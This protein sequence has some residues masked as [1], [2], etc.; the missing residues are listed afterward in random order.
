MHSRGKK[1]KVEQA[2][3]LCSRDE[4]V[5][6]N[7]VNTAVSDQRG[8]IEGFCG[9][10]VPLSR[11]A[12]VLLPEEGGSDEKGVLLCN[13]A[14]AA[15]SSLSLK[16]GSRLSDAFDSTLPDPK[17]A[18]LSTAL[19]RA[20]CYFAERRLRLD[21]GEALLP[22][23]FQTLSSA[24]TK[25]FLLHPAGC[26]ASTVVGAT[27]EA[28]VLKATSKRQFPKGCLQARL[29]TALHSRPAICDS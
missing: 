13:A 25:L 21:G 19:L 10:Q 3:I 6:L 17:S 8:N 7:S 14:L 27:F 1:R 23:L 11:W 4:V 16:F 29:H 15:G 20:L 18:H 2:A 12:A 26:E 24:I 5:P 9:H 28:A 22:S